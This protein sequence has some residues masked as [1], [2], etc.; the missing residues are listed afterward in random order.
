MLTYR[1]TKIPLKA[2]AQMWMMYT[3]A[4]H[5][6]KDQKNM[7]IEASSDWN[8]S[9]WAYYIFYKYTN[10]HNVSLASY[11]RSPKAFLFACAQIEQIVELFLAP[12]CGHDKTILISERR[13]LY[14]VIVC[15]S[16]ANY[17]F[18]WMNKFTHEMINFR[19]IA[20]ARKSFCTRLV[21]LH[22]V[23]LCKTSYFKLYICVYYTSMMM[24]SKHC[25]KHFSGIYMES[26]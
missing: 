22:V 15:L 1:K 4:R 5:T 9:L 24:M 2:C 16:Y 17:L 10:S 23:D 6:F 12:P 7:Q 13:N 14:F 25:R 19:I 26:S 20:Y 21:L 11:I 3:R 18:L 8:F